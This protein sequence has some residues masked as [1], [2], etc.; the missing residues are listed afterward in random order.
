[1]RIGAGVSNKRENGLLMAN[2]VGL[3]PVLAAALADAQDAVDEY[4]NACAWLLSVASAFTEPL[5]AEVWVLNPTYTQVLLVAHRWRGWVPPGGSAEPGESPRDAAT[6][7]LIEETG[8]RVA[9]LGRPAAAAVRSYRQGWPVTLGISYVAV[10]DESAPAVG[11]PGQPLSW[12][13]LAG[14]S[15]LTDFGP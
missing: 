3:T 4:D 7:E 8:I 10:V 15:G 12:K 13:P 9:L 5:A 2:E 11:E 6:R 1:V 14:L